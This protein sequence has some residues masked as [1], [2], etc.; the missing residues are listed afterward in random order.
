MNVEGVIRG[1]EPEKMSSQ[2]EEFAT[3]SARS[4][5]YKK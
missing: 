5:Q 1:K 4:K 2:H 3:D